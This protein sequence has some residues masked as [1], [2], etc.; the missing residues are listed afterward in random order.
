MVWWM[1]EEFWAA[2]FSQNQKVTAAGTEGFLKTVRPYTI[3]AV[4]DG[5]VGP[6][7]GITYRSE[8][9]L[10]AGMR[11]IDAQGTSYP[12]LTDEQLSADLKNL[13]QIMKPMLANMLGPLGQN[14][15]FFV[16]PGTTRA[17]ARIANATAKGHF[18]VTLEKKEY[19]WR[20]PLDSLLPGKVCPDCHEPCKGSWNFCPWCGAKLPQRQAGATVIR[21]PQQGR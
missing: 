1:P 6:F 5:T 9:Q 15:Q 2:S 10:R 12:P 16:F 11:L 21:G 17:G 14:M 8:E 7:G 13:L 20:L 3:I 19:A 4:F 18:K